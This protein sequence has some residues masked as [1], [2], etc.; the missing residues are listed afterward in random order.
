MIID[1]VILFCFTN[2]GNGVS[3]FMVVCC[4]Y[5]VFQNFRRLDYFNLLD[6]IL[7][8]KIY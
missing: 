2:V 7:S 1:S 6:I 5:D 8:A 4:L 3:V